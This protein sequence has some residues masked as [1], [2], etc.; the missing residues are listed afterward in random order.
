M[1]VA[2]A[3]RALGSEI[4]ARVARLENE[5]DDA[6]ALEDDARISWRGVRVA[7]L[8]AGIDALS[9][10]LEMLPSGHLGGA[11]RTRAEARL[12][13]WFGDQLT[14]VLAPLVRLRDAPLT[15]PSLRSM[16]LSMT[17]QYRPS[18]SSSLSK[19]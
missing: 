14:L 2:A 13:R 7:R 3:K 8:S 4:A 10:R 17:T 11:L 5:P 9:P 1:L 19:F 6:F 16:A 15:G 12:V 18:W